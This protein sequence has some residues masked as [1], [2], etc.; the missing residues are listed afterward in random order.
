MINNSIKIS[1]AWKHCYQ[2]ISIKKHKFNS[3]KNKKT[4]LLLHSSTTTLSGLTALTTL[5]T[6][7]AD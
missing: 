3:K 7:A 1:T 6:S 4:C 5:S 2:N